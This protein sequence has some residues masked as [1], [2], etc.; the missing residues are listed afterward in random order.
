MQNPLEFYQKEKQLFEEQF[1]KVKKQ[2]TTSS[3]LRLFVF[4]V[5][6]FGVYFFFGNGKAMTLVVLI[7]ITIFL[8]LVSKHTDLQHKKNKIQSL[9][10]INETE[11]KLPH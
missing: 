9:I 8:F 6:V 1:S 4:I 7:G 2:L 3:M 11:I 10:N 5:I